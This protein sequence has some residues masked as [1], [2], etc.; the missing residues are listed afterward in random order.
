MTRKGAIGDELGVT[1]PDGFKVAVHEEGADVA[2]VVLPPSG[3]LNDADLQAVAAGAAGDSL[4]G[5]TPYTPPTSL[6]D[7]NQFPS[8]NY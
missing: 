6:Q 4:G 7:P 1:L 2:H 5:G 8:R 3:P